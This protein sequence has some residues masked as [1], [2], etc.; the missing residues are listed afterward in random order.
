MPSRWC[1]SAVSPARTAAGVALLAFL[2]G[3][4][5]PPPAAAAT[6]LDKTVRHQ[7]NAD[8]SVVEDT[9]LRVL[10]KVGADLEE[11]ADYFVYL[12][13]HR[14]LESVAAR[15]VSP[16]GKST[17]VKKK[18]QDLIE[19]GGPSWQLHGSARYH[20]LKLTGLTVGSVVE[21][22]H[23]VRVSPYFPGGSVHLFDEG[24]DVASLSVE[25]SGAPE[26]FRWR[27]D[28]TEAELK[29]AET[30][31]GLTLAGEGLPAPD[32]PDYAPD[33]ADR[34]PVL[35]YAWGPAATWDEVGRWHRE[36]IR[37]L[38]S[39]APGVRAKARELIAGIDDPRAR[40]E[41]LLA[42]ARRDVRYVAV[43]VG[44]GGFQPSPAAETLARGWG[45]CK[46]KSLLLT[47]LLAEAGIEAFPAIVRLDDRGRIDPAFPTPFVFNHVIVAIPADGLTVTDTDPVSAGFLFVDPTDDRST[48]RWLHE[49]VQD[50]HALVVRETGA[51]LVPTPSL[52]DQNR[53]QLDVTVAVGPDGTARGR[54]ELSLSGAP[55]SW[56]RSLLADAKPHEVEETARRVFASLL[57]AVE[58]GSVSWG[59]DESG[60][61]PRG[62][63][64]AEVSVPGLV[65]A[66]GSTSFAL[67]ALSGT[68]SV[69]ILDERTEPVVLSPGV[70]RERWTLTLP[71]QG[72]R[73]ETE[74]VEVET[75]VGSYRQTASAQGAVLT[76]E[77]DL[78]LSA[79]WI[80]PD[81]FA[82]L[83]ELSLAETRAKKRRLRLA[84]GGG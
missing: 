84:C 26:G 59:L 49:G 44:I 4:A 30:T 12:D 42:F 71:R 10:I 28:G 27:L 21:V 5:A 67:P 65:P 52:F 25:V 60:P 8:G 32:P 45:D 83:K 2:A 17:E 20:R 6:V 48:S 64:S 76:V 80:E 56:V 57:P 18:D 22:E 14:T 46:D 62:L 16:D 79:R 43:E 70:S 82:A 31:T 35:R 24:A 54:A 7:I 68:P 34:G 50:Q 81:G 39:A 38:P 58:L 23:R 40:L 77:R 69:S 15:V 73:P 29:I 72:C 36:L 41:A 1:S 3:G 9:R 61:A 53:R 74:D 47:E 75:A 11:W 63:F 66:G 55:G 37:E 13:D 19:T 78:T 33:D 51:A